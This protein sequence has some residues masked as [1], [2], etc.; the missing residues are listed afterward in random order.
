M[1]RSW[2]AGLQPLPSS[3]LIED[4]RRIERVR[5]LEP[6]PRVLE[7]RMDRTQRRELVVDTVEK[8]LFISLVVKDGEFRSVQK[9]ARVQS[10]DGNEVAPVLSAISPDPRPRSSIQSCHKK[11]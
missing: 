1:S 6:G 2:I 4:I 9:P 3:I 10:T 8:V 7:V 11:R 5:C